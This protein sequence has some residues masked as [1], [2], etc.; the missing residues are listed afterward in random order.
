L[1]PNC[2]QAI[3][4]QFGA[5]K[6][7]AIAAMFNP[8]YTEEELAALLNECGAKLA[9]VLTPYYSKLKSIQSKCGLKQIIATNIKEHLPPL[10]RFLFTLFKEKKG[11]HRISLESGDFRF[12]DLLRK[13]THSTPPAV[14]IHRDDP[15]LLLFTGGTTGR[16]K[17]AVG[18]HSG[19]FIAAS[20]I[21]AWFSMELEDWADPFVGTFPVF[22][23]AGNVAVLGTAIV[24]RHPYIPIPD[25]R[26]IDDLVD[27]VM[28]TRPGLF[29]GVPTLFNAL[30][31][32][33]DVQS[34][35]A[36]FSSIKVCISG[37]APLMAETKRRFDSVT[38]GSMV[39]GYA[40][41]ESM[42]AGVFVPVHS[43]Y[44]EGSVGLPLPDVEVR[45]ADPESG[46]GSMPSGEVGEIL[47]QAPQI[48]Q[49]YWNQPEA[50]SEA[51]RSGWL[52]TGDMGYLDE[53]GYLFI[54]DRKKDLIKPSGFQ[55]WPREVEEV[56]ASHPA[57]AEVGV[58]GIPDDYQGESVKAWVV[59][60]K[61]QEISVD[62]IV[63]FCKGKLAGYKVPKYVEF[64]DS[65]PKSTV[66]KVL[67]REL[68]KEAKRE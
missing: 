30:L 28:K 40:L 27:T 1:L 3:I 21:H 58:A 5:W 8:L 49:G 48:M 2:P 63:D 15:A 47:I 12:A 59:R 11:G 10:L 37:S 38:G 32:H 18:T 66:G 35:K 31:N 25:P 54:V 34:G 36:G 6:A 39:E 57:V 61:N 7:G 67:R 41:T 45:I 26:D 9:L 51:I 53:D 13:E 46:E 50:T 56:I 20:Q 64:R 43:Q 65:L 16:P 42:M 62:E 14:E 23:V 17:G 60:R 68:V 52:H 19:L 33:K 4:G 55:V 44:K 29:P 24:G 22:H